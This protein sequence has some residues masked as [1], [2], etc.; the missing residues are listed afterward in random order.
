LEDAVWRAAGFESGGFSEVRWDGS[1]AAAKL[2][3]GEE[4]A[5]AG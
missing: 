2:A 5:D 3:A 1:E 4:R